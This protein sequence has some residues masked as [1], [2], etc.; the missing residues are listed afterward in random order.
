MATPTLEQLYQT[1]RTQYR[2]YTEHTPLK[3]DHDFLQAGLVWGIDQGNQ[4]PPVLLIALESGHW[5]YSRED[6]LDLLA[7]E[8]L[9][10]VHGDWP[11]LAPSTR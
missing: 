1:I 8:L 10:S 9:G 6:K 7:Y 11:V 4:T 3:S 2:D 5:D